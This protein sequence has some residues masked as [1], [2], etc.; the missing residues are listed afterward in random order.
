MIGD[1]SAV[2]SV[3]PAEPHSLECS[4]AVKQIAPGIWRLLTEVPGIGR[5][6]SAGASRSGVEYIISQTRGRKQGG[7]G[8]T[9]RLCINESGRSD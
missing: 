1:G 2:L 7:P 9:G 4:T 3:I 8:A 6:S 5:H